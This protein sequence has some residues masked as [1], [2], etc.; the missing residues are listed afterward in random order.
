MHSAMITLKTTLKKTGKFGLLFSSPTSHKPQ[1]CGLNNG[2]TRLIIKI[3]TKYVCHCPTSRHVTL[4]DNRTMWTLNWIMKICRWGERKKKRSFKYRGKCKNLNFQTTWYRKKTDSKIFFEN[5]T[6]WIDIFKN[7]DFFFALF[8]FA[9]P[10]F[11]FFWI[12]W[13]LY[14]NKEKMSK[15]YI[16]GRLLLWKV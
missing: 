12:S 7:F 3:K 16:H 10:I 6:H 14:V 13:F 1:F 4:H 8:Q 5:W 9:T 11:H 2:F 15:I